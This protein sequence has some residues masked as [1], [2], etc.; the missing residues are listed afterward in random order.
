MLKKVVDI[1]R[2]ASSLMMVEDYEIEIKGGFA[3]IVTS[4]DINIQHLLHERLSQLIPGSG[5]KCEEEGMFETG[6]EYEWIIDPIDGTA[7]FARGF[8]ESSI[9]VALI[10]NNEPIVGVVYNPF[11]DQMFSAERGK[12]AFL[13]GKPIHVSERV[14]ENSIYFT[15]LCL[16]RKQYSPFCVDVLQDVFYQICDFRRFASVALEICY[17]AMGCGEL[18]FEIRVLPWDIAASVLILT[19]A[20]GYC[21]S[22]HGERLSFDTPIPFIAAN[23]KENLDRMSSIV[24]KHI[25]SIPYKGFE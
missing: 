20:G 18:A 14:F 16:Y 1:V 7:N 25:P 15:G 10:H 2:E 8:N 9:C 21:C 17:L 13:N 24:S 12:G 4:V 22:L 19:E 5:F 3:D 11:K 6:C 23:T